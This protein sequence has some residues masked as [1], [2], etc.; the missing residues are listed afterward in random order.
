MF[1]RGI[2]RASWRL[3]NEWGMSGWGFGGFSHVCFWNE[4]TFLWG[5]PCDMAGFIAD[6]SRTGQDF[7]TQVCTR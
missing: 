7:C 1:L 4:K 3:W 2:G 5:G 6:R